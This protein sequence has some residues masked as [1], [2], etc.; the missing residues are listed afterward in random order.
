MLRLGAGLV[1][2]QHRVD[3]DPVSTVAGVLILV[4]FLTPFAAAWMAGAL[5]V[6]QVTAPPADLNGLS[7]LLLISGGAALALLGPGAFSVDARL[8]GRR[9]IVIPRATVKSKR[10]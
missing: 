7:V 8:F 4:G 1:V 3:I 6:L 9:E 10:E 2:V 5:A